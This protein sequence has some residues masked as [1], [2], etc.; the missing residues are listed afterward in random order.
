M[1]HRR[2]CRRRRVY[3][4]ERTTNIGAEVDLIGDVHARGG[5]VVRLHLN[6][7]ANVQVTLRAGLTIDHDLG[8]RGVELLAVEVHAAEAGDRAG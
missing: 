4:L 6:Y 7:V 8:V 1:R 3:R 2:I 5:I